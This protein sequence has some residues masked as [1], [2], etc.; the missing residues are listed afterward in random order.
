MGKGGHLWRDLSQR[1][2]RRHL[3]GLQLSGGHHLG[4]GRQVRRQDRGHRLQR[5]LWCQDLRQGRRLGQRRR[6]EGGKGLL[7]PTSC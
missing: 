5:A 1:L 2:Q 7:R 6:L 3:E 4:A